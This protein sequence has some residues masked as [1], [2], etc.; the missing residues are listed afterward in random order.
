VV[1]S[2]YAGSFI[3]I[4]FFSVSSGSYY[5]PKLELTGANADAGFSPVE[6]GARLENELFGFSASA[7]LSK[8][9]PS[10]PP[11]PKTEALPLSLAVGNAIVGFCGGA[12]TGD[13]DYTP[14][15]GNRV[16]DELGAGLLGPPINAEVDDP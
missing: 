12:G 5:F 13:L 1:T 6:L 7:F 9:A 4:S 15:V 16:V 3:N 14:P 10:P 8:S 2:G 11:P